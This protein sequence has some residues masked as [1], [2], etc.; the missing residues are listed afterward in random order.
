MLPQEGRSALTI[1]LPQVSKPARQRAK[2]QRAGT[3]LERSFQPLQPFSLDHIKGYI[4]H[5]NHDF[6][7]LDAE[8]IGLDILP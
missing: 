2:G 1:V 3:L 6:A 8:A 4:Q 7:G 5:V